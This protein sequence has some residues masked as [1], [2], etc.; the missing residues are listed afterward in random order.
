MDE[1]L[2][3]MPKI[4]NII[5]FVVISGGMIF[6][7]L[8]FI[9]K[10]TKQPDLVTSSPSGVTDSTTP[11][12]TEVDNQLSKDFLAVLLS[13][14]NITLDDS[15]FSDTAFLNLKDSTIV[16]L[17]DGSEGRPNPFAPI[18]AENNV[19]PDAVRSGFEPL[20]L[21][22][23]AEVKTDTTTTKPNTTKKPTR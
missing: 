8:T 1:E 21:K 12:G 6:G 3:A 2:V 4:R 9:K 19:I 23:E 18:G 5:I 15:I 20:D 13:I 16:L 7:Y 11:S 14:K 22:E 17:P 10:D